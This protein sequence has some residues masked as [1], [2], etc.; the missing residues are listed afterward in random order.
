LYNFYYQKVANLLPKS[1]EKFMV[2]I[3]FAGDPIL[4]SLIPTK[5]RKIKTNALRLFAR[6]FCAK[7]LPSLA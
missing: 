3:G 2:F 1:G 7:K 5:L 6:I 4:H